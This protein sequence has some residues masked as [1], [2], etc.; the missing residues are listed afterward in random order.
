MN[1]KI[2]GSELR[3][4]FIT[5]FEKQGHTHVASSSLIPDNDP[6]LLFSNAGMNQFKD[7]F[8]GSQKRAYTRA[9]TSQKCL[10]ISGKHNDLENVGVTARHHTFFEMLGNFSFGDYF[11]SD[12]IKFA[13]QFITETLQ[14]NKNRL[15]VT[16]FEKDDEAGQLWKELTDINPERIL[17]LGEKD[18]FWAMGETGPCGPCSEIHYFMGKDEALQSEAGFRKEDGSYLEIWNLVFMQ[19]DRQS[20]G[21]L[22]PL[23]KPSV[24]TGMGLERIASILQG[25]SSN[26]DTDLLRGVIDECEKLSGFKYDGSSYKERDLKSDINYARDVAMRVIADHSRAIAFLI[27]DGVVPGSDGRGYV[28]RRLIRRAAR[29]GRVLN[30]S[31]TFLS[32]T[33]RRVIDMFGA[34]YP[35]LIERQD[36][37]ARVVEGEECKFYETLDAGLIILEKENEKLSS[38]ELFPG[39]AAFLLHDTYGFPLD[40]TEDALKVHGRKIDLSAFTEEMEAQKKRSRDD[41]KAHGAAFISFKLE[42]EKSEFLGYESL[43][44]K[45]KVTAVFNSDGSPVTKI[46]AGESAFIFFDKTPFYAESGG[47]VGDCGTISIGE[48]TLKVIDT[49]K[50]QDGHF[51]HECQIISGALDTK[52]IG[53]DALLAVDQD[54]RIRIRSNHSATHLLHYALK[55]VLGG[56]VKQAGSKVDDETLRFDFTHFAALTE[57]ELEK[58]QAIINQEIRNNYEIKTHIMQIDEAKKIGATA[59][60]GE[61]Y[62]DQVRV[63][64]IGPNSLELCGGTHATRSGDIGFLVIQSDSG[65]SAGVRRIECIAGYQA[66]NYLVAAQNERRKLFEILKGDSTNLGEKVERLQS[67]IKLLERELDTAKS[68]L[69]SAASGELLASTRTTPNGIKVIAE[70][71]E[72]TDT[73][74]LKNM[75]DGLRVKIGSGLVALASNQGEQ[76]FI[77]AGATSDLAKTI[78]VGNIIKEA[79][80]IG[81]GRG[82]GRVDFA[83]AGGVDPKLIEVTLNKVFELVS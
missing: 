13:W 12:A 81:G 30:F 55:K 22:V 64:E 1:K 28:L 61:K 75:V 82:G 47:Q 42:C 56:H 40:L 19:F 67:R 3:K 35:D 65:I 4:A 17:K 57:S 49:Q 77:I 5:F 36:I 78:N 7:C 6:T 14:L 39:K 68:R 26:Y 69:A 60:F 59:L 63:V 62:G 18:N 83:Q 38:N 45:S 20:D 50:I 15:W 32:K 41:R 37:I 25:V 44:S 70:K 34:N 23:P 16:I 24:D 76:G 73:E 29:H 80:K 79:V 48:T 54:R 66:D 53:K 33:T 10:R 31:H 72:A 27:A 74:T 9:A 8:L 2:S 71:V 43:N 21:T 51:V 52:T 58:A 46:N 11:K